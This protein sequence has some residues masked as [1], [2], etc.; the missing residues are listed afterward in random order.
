M[1]QLTKNKCLHNMII[2]THSFKSIFDAMDKPFSLLPCSY[3]YKDNEIHRERE[4]R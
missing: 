4:S 2:Y 3:D 1:E